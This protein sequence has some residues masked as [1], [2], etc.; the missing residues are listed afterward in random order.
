ME[1]HLSNRGKVTNE[2]FFQIKGGKQ[3]GFEM[4][5]YTK[6]LQELFDYIYDE[7]GIEFKIN[8]D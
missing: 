2:C 5:Y 7:T 4:M 3:V 8:S 6:K 1:Y